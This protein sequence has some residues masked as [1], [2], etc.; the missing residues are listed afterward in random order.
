MGGCCGF[1]NCSLHLNWNQKRKSRHHLD[2]YH[3]QIQ[4]YRDFGIT[5]SPIGHAILLGSFALAYGAMKASSDLHMNLI[6]NCLRSPMIFFDTTPVGRLVNR[7]SRDLDT[8]DY[9][10]P[11]ATEWWLKCI[12]EV[13]GTIFI[14]C[15]GTPLFL[16]PLLPLLIFYYIVQ[17]F[18]LS[19]FHSYISA[20]LA[21]SWM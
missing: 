20:S 10:I 9:L 21:I 2:Y 12:N 17:V 19:K 15:Y 13:L 5:C 6:S 16:V 8:I 14:I 1:K 7:F 4:Y 18:L 11:K 3:S